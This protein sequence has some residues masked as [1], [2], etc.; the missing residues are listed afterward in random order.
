MSVFLREYQIHAGKT[1]MAASLKKQ[2]PEE[3]EAIDEYMRLMKV[4]REEK[5]RDQ[6]KPQAGFNKQTIV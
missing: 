3:E 4:E 1:E 6:T 5:R 2:F